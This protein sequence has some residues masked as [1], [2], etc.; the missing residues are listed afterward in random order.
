MARPSATQSFAA[1]RGRFANLCRCGDCELRRHGRRDVFCSSAAERTFLRGSL[2]QVGPKRADYFW[3]PCG[4][5]VCEMREWMRWES[6][7]R[8]SR[9]FRTYDVAP[10]LLYAHLVFTNT[11]NPRSELNP[12]VGGIVGEGSAV[13]TLN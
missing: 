10:A 13:N 7:A 11:R 2:A 8:L 12:E 6:A 3:P 4:R 5:G 9:E 1:T